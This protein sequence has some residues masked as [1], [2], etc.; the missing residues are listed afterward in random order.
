MYIA[1]MV[2]LI[3]RAFFFFFYG[4][5]VINENDHRK[6]L[7]KALNVLSKNRRTFPAKAAV[8]AII[9]RRLNTALL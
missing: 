8:R 1:E 5:S 9:T 2:L 7:N 4:F 3:R 6:A